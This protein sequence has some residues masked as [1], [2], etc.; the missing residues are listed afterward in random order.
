MLGKILFLQNIFQLVSFKLLGF[1]AF[2]LNIG[3]LMSI[4]VEN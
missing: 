4:L 2:L 3:L 1:L